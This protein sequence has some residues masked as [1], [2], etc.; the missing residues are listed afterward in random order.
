ML[1]ADIDLMNERSTPTRAQDNTPT[2]RRNRTCSRVCKFFARRFFERD[3]SRGREEIVFRR[4]LRKIGG[5]WNAAERSVSE[6]LR[7][8]KVGRGR[9]ELSGRRGWKT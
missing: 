9:A 1:R 2:L 5:T 6:M 8:E 7:G 4:G 3:T